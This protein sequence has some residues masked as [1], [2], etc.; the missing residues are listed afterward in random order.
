MCSGASSNEVFVI[1]H[2]ITFWIFTGPLWGETTGELSS[3]RANNDS[4][5]V[6]LKKL[7]DSWIAGDYRR[8]VV[9]VTPTAICP[10]CR[11]YEIAT[12][13]WDMVFCPI[14]MCLTVDEFSFILFD[15]CL[16]ITI[17][18]FILNHVLIVTFWIFTYYEIWILSNIYCFIWNYWIIY[19][20]TCLEVLWS[21]MS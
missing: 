19:F 14:Y 12:K 4:F 1:W 8:Q 3:R 21:V 5:T 17:L 7:L 9:H 20:V 6:S 11:T 15:F 18:L 16:F 13:F 2:G 10:V